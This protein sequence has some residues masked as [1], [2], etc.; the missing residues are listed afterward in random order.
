MLPGCLAIAAPGA[1]EGRQCSG[2]VHQD[3]APVANQNGWANKWEGPPVV[4]SG[5]F[6]SQLPEGM[7]TTENLHS[8]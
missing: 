3:I 6:T 8:T 7:I 1:P 4:Y 2:S 5:F